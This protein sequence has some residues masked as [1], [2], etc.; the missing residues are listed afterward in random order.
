MQ[1]ELVKLRVAGE[2]PFS[3]I[4]DLW[5]RRPR[6]FDGPEDAL[7]ETARLYRKSLWAR[8]DSRVEIWLEKDALAGV[9]VDVTAETDVPLMVTRGYPS[10]TFL[11][12]AAD[13]IREAGHPTFVYHCGDYDP[14]GQDA[15]RVVER[16]LRELAP[17]VEI[18]FERSAVTPAQILEFELL[19]G[20]LRR[21]ICA[22]RNSAKS[23]SSWKR[24]ILM[25]CAT[26]PRSDRT[27]SAATR[28]GGDEGSRT[29]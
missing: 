17:G 18:H 29:A 10:L 28:T 7:R 26:S 14:S 22:P 3:W 9:I 8:A 13:Q 19:P 21:P 15:A 11:A 1:R 23:Q 5:Q 4:A 25:F 16:K 27:S 12:S 24:C 2:L 6:T 20:R